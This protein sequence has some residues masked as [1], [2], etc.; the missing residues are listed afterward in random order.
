MARLS[1][2]GDLI[3]RCVRDMLNSSVDEVVC[4]SAPIASRLD[5]YLSERLASSVKVTALA[6]EDVLKKYGVLD[7]VEKLLRSKVRLESGGN[8]VIDYTEALTVIDV[9]TAKF[10]GDTDRENTVFQINCEA[11]REIARQ[12][13]LRN[14]GGMVVIDFIDMTDPAHNEEVVEILRR[15]AALDRMRTRVLPMT[16]LGLV[17]MTRKKSG[18]ELQSLLLQRCRECNGTA[19]TVSPNFLMR[20]IKAQLTEIF[21]D[22]NCAS[23]VVS[24]SNTI[25]NQLKNGEWRLYLGKYDDRRV[26]A[27]ASSEVG[28]NSFRISARSSAE[29]PENAYVLN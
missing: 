26:F 4:N 3:F 29:M 6:D 1:T 19:H 22:A 28:A 25:Y 24:V 7:D 13:R 14:V 11:A 17:Q 27:V 16:E 10:I 12:L 18:V 21:N 9:N 5:K 23:A 15:E 20:R 8:L 2:D